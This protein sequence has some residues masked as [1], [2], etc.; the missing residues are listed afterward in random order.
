LYFIAQLIALIILVYHTGRAL[1]DLFGSIKNIRIS[2]FGTDLAEVAL[3][4]KKNSS[5]F[6]RYLD[7]ILHF[8]ECTTYQ[9]VII[10]DLD[11]FNDVEI[12]TRLRSL[13]KTI[14]NYPPIKG[15]DNL[16]K[17]RIRFIYAVKDDLF[18]KD[19]RDRTKFFDIIIPII[20]V[21][22]F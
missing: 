6:N 11:R 5:I 13:N 3:D 21:I 10:E 1:I 4:D 14:N 8:F 22:S 17:R 9:Y 19:S 15:E 12:F 7:E 18:V 2:K 16:N 20:P